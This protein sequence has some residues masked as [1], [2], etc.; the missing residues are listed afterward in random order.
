M[1]LLGFYSSA[2]SRGG[3]LV[4]FS[5]RNTV[6]EPLPTLYLYGLIQGPN[7]P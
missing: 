3:Y 1:F 5:D 2:R 7:Q 6:F 4:Q